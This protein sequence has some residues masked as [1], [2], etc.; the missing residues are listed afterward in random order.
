MVALANQNFRAT[1]DGVQNDL[2]NVH[3]TEIEN[4][5]IDLMK[6]TYEDLYC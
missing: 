4:Q 6:A 2:W 5:I 3:D 1:L